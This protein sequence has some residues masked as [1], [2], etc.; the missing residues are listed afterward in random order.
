MIDENEADKLYLEAWE[1]EDEGEPG[2]AIALFARAA[3]LGHVDAMTNLANLYADRVSPPKL[4]AAVALYKRAIELG[5]AMAA[6][7]LAMH[8][9][10]Y[11]DLEMRNH[12]IRIAAEMGDGDAQAVVA[13]DSWMAMPRH[14]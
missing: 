2:L 7:N 6:W 11:D 12:W 8:Y 13:Q 14:I 10:I 1:R 9:Q 4:D 5:S 3:L